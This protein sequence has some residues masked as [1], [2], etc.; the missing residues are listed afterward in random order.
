MRKVLAIVG[1][2]LVVAVAGVL[3]YASA[4]PD[5][6]RVARSASI[7]AS[8]AK[9]FAFVNDFRSWPLWSPY[10]KK[11]PAMKR[12]LSGPPAGLG[13]VY[14][15]EGNGEVGQGR[16]EIIEAIPASKVAIKLD[17]IKPFEGHNMAE[18]T[19]ERKGDAT[20]VTWAMYGPAP[21]ITKLIGVFIDLDKMI[22]RDFEAGL[23]NL[24]AATES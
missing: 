23:E 3:L 1:G 14:A 19:L 15:W 22:G 10:E 18:F 6:F 17:F 8:P 16:M 13:S 24:K 21:F 12:M 5:T 9:I 20:S 2:V 7:K 11:D 4:Q